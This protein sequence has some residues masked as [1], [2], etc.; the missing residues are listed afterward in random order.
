MKQITDSPPV[1]SRYRP[2][3]QIRGKARKTRWLRTTII[4]GLLV[5]TIHFLIKCHTYR[6]A[7][8]L[9]YTPTT[10]PHLGA[11]EQAILEDGTWQWEM[12]IGS[13]EK[14]SGTFN[15][16]DFLG[17]RSEWH[18]LGRGHEGETFRYEES[19][20]KVFRKHNA[21][22]RN[23][24]PGTTPEVRWPTEISAS[25][26]L[27]GGG[28]VVGAE[29]EAHN[30]ITKETT[31]LP[32]T[33]YFLS[34]EVDGKEARWHFITPLLPLGGLGK[35][36][37]RFHEEDKVYT[38]RQLDVMFRPSL[39]HL[40]LGLDEMHMTHELCHDDVKLDNIFVASPAASNDQVEGDDH[41]PTA[42]KTT[43]WLL[44]DLGNVREISH[45]Y[46]SSILWLA[47]KKNL[48]DCRANDVVRL[49]KVYMTFLRRSVQ[50]QALFDK[51]FFEGAEPWSALFWA[52]W[53][54]TRGEGGST[55]ATA[56]LEKSR[57][58]YNPFGQPDHSGLRGQ[59][60]P[61]LSKPLYR[62]FLGKER[63]LSM[64][65]GFM[66]NVAANEAH[67]RRWG[68]APLLG[69]PYSSCAVATS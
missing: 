33:D 67:A 1:Y 8:T 42:N 9:K 20:V 38:A 37:K 2:W 18:K 64:A 45:P 3:P 53:T 12:S 23:C 69:V 52:V 28:N 61:E 31:F 57:V 51:E 66:L 46:H 34:P 43:H 49:L 14:G 44:G 22:F 55:S 39:E 5:G 11:K 27:G 19:V 35:L 58:Q 32:V 15:R 24:V 40:L 59:Q 26:I 56:A 21:P 62:V 29:D 4:A 68:L 36:A 7:M 17:H 50:D 60:V 16:E 47:S 48:S 63:I 6:S 41:I 54:S 30:R 13:S 25:L 65:T 10:F